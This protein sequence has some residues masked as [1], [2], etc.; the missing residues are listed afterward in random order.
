MPLCVQLNS[1]RR[2]DIEEG[3]INIYLDGVRSTDSHSVI[4]WPT[5]HT[6]DHWSKTTHVVIDLSKH[7][8]SF[9]GSLTCCCSASSWRKMREKGS[10]WSWRRNFQSGTW[11]QLWSKSTITTRPV[12]SPT[13]LI[14]FFISEGRQDFWRVFDVSGDEAVTEYT[15]PCAESEYGGRGCY[16]SHNRWLII[17]MIIIIIII[18]INILFDF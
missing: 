11:N 9:V 3:F 16:L 10:V 4:S 18:I 14:L 5:G 13:F 15:S 2:V 12:R 17:I 6:A 7:I 1:V 8:V